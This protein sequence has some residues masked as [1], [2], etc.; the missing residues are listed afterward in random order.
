MNNSR[1]EKHELDH[2]I[3]FTK[4]YK[5]IPD[6]S[7]REAACLEMQLPHIL[8][9]IQEGDL[10]AGS[11]RHGYVGFSP[12]YGGVY[13]YY[14]HGDR[15]ERAIKNLGNTLTPEYLQ[16]IKDLDTFWQTENTTAKYMARFSEKYLLPALDSYYTISSRI[17]GVSLDFK[18]LIELGLDGL[19]THINNHANKNGDSNFYQG[20]QQVVQTVSA[21]CKTYASHAE[22]L[23]VT[24]DNKTELLEIAKILRTIAHQKPTTFREGLQLMWIYS[25]CSDLTNYGRMDIYLG[26]LYA[27][28]IAAGAI[29]FED[30]VTYLRS[31]FKLMVRM[32]K[33]HDARVI[34]G[35]EG[36]P[37]EKNA[38]ELA[39]AIIEAS[40]REMQ[41]I[42]QLTLRYYTGIDDRLMESSLR[43]I[44]KGHTFPIIYSDN[45]TIPAMEKNF[46]VDRQMA[47]NWV[48]FGCGEYI[49][50]GYGI[51]TPNTLIMFSNILD[52]L[53]HGGY[54]SFTGN[55]IVD[56]YENVCYETFDE[57]M[58]A[59]K[60]LI[61]PAAEQGAYS[62][63]CNYA[64]AG[65]EASFLLYSLLTHDCVGK[66]KPMLSG[67]VRYLCAT[68]ETLGIMTCTDSLMA[69]R[70][71]VYEEKRFTLQELV[72]MMDN[73]FEGFET[74]RQLLLN[75]PK[76]GNDND[77]VDEMAAWL[78]AMVSDIHL[79][80]GK[81]TNLYRYNVVSVT[82][83]AS[84]DMGATTA[85]TPD[86]RKRG[87]PLNN[88]NSPSI[89][90]EQNGLTAA[91]SSMAKMDP[92]KHVGVTHNV[93][94][95]KDFFASKFNMIKA[96]LETFYENGG[97]Q[98]NLSCV[99]K[100]DLQQAIK[101]PEK[102]KDLMVRI[103]GFSARFVE[104]N[105]IVQHEI[106][107]RTTHEG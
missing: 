5:S 81:K 95:N 23:A 27:A 63:E 68:N 96:A 106:L 52:I 66:G 77:E 15:V 16:Q 84:A 48:P 41:V 103:G 93:R 32:G 19:I 90:A 31:V 65:E 37:N 91:L 92:Y 20:L 76:Y 55:K 3:V 25:I 71:L 18:P 87:E 49:L 36:R 59:Y 101:H 44:Q 73:N 107:L 86:G 10:F 104:L 89:G 38:N 98:T 57:L 58:Q 79:E 64:V 67:G 99:G 26:D 12:Q 56:G 47:Q 1:T 97:V 45:T 28:D 70:R 94:L 72:H 50:E 60:S 51:G 78:F 40:T 7:L 69:I 88:G 61:Y 24:S 62:E 34:V 80:A 83:S 4:L 17:S 54:N 8:T 6:P 46:A 82:N 53:L 42:P 105:P 102:Y 30:A 22:E 14:Y 74:E 85:A 11:M 35:G 9:P 39:L 100:D 75:A 21:T 29:T 43:S 2:A 13:T 33:I